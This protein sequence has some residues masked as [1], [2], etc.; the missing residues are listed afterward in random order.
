MSNAFQTAAGLTVLYLVVA[1]QVDP[2]TRG[3]DVM[4][5]RHVMSVAD[6]VGSEFTFR[7]V[8][9]SLMALVLWWRGLVLAS[10]SNPVGT[11]VDTFKRGV[12][13]IACAALWTR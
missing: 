3:F 13:T 12:V 6:P 11:I 4:W 5:A 7:A 2:A 1:N 9:G 8:V 10:S